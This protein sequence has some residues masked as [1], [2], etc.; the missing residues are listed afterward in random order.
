MKLRANHIVVAVL[1]LVAGVVGVILA[2]TYQ[3]SEKK[4]SG[5]NND[6]FLESVRQ[7]AEANPDTAKNEVGGEPAGGVVPGKTPAIDVPEQ[8]DVGLIPNDKT[9]TH[10]LM[11]RNKGTYDLI[12]GSITTSC[13]CTVGTVAQKTVPPGGE[14]PMTITID[15]KRIPG[16]FSDKL[17]TIISNDPKNSMAHVAVTANVEPEFAVEPPEVK[18]DKVQK[19]QTVKAQVVLRQL[20]QAPF[21]DKPFEIKNVKVAQDKPAVQASVAARP[22]SEWKTPGFPEYVVDVTLDSTALPVGEFDAVLSLDTT[23]P[24]LFNYRVNLHADV[25]AAGEAAQTGSPS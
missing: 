8:H 15:P 14:V 4:S 3:S 18:F 12:I 17:L 19:G 21:K 23:C 9:S 20:Q 13:A 10:T 6:E 16:F 25:V 22:E 7:E 11:I 24:R 1:V 5:G 2:A